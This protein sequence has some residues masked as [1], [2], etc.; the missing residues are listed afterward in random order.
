MER[1][2]LRLLRLGLGSLDIRVALQEEEHSHGD[3]VRDVGH[4]L[5]R[6]AQQRDAARGVP[7]RSGAAMM[8][9][10]AYYGQKREYDHGAA[11]GYEAPYDPLGYKRQRGE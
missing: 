4:D 8:G 3:A 7:Q 11:V 10:G 6:Q 1:G 9:G 5:A 2:L